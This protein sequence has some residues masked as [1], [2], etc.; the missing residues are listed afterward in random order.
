MKRWL[1]LLAAAVMLAAGAWIFQK[2]FP[3]DEKVIR[4]T[5]VDVERYASFN[6]EE[7]PL[8][9]LANVQKLA[10]FFT[11]DVVIRLSFDEDSPRAIEG[12]ETLKQAAMG[13]RSAMSSLRLEMLEPRMQIAPDR[14]SATVLLA[15][16][17]Y[18]SDGDLQVQEIRLRLRKVEKR[19][20]I[21]RVDAV[22]NQNF[23]RL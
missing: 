18:P 14:S 17:V 20:F 6:A 10:S 9:R 4:Q 12:R 2:L 8:S 19:W 16:K 7:K 23:K 22:K 1:W 3:G 21:E 5:L 13:A 15:L 11:E